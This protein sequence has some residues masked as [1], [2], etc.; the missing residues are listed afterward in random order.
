ME[1]AFVAPC[2]GSASRQENEGL[3]HP[4]R[5]PGRRSRHLCA[6]QEVG[7]HLLRHSTDLRMTAELV[8]H[9]AG[10]LSVEIVCWMAL[11]AAVAAAVVEFAAE[12]AEVPAAAEVLVVG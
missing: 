4:D 6:H 3:R 5:S 8:A 10:L 2:L 9:P 7:I 1:A 12:K 11:S